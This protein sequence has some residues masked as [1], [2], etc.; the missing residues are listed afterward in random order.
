M[1]NRIVEF[2]NRYKLFKVD[3]T[4]DIYDLL[5]VPGEVTS[6]GTPYAK[7]T[8]LTDQTS[9][10][11][12]LDKTAVPDT[13]FAHIYDRLMW[14]SGDKALITLKVIDQNNKPVTGVLIPVIFDAAG[15]AVKT[16]ADG[17]AKGLIK[18]GSVA[19]SIT[20]YADIEPFN[21][22]KEFVK[23]QVY[24]ETITITRRNYVA[25]TTS[26]YIYFSDDVDTVDAS[27]GGAG[28][29]GGNDT[30]RGVAGDG[31]DYV[32]AGTGSGDGYVTTKE[33]LKPAQGMKYQAIIG[34]G[35]SPDAAGGDTTFM[36][37][38]A[39]GG[40]PKVGGKGG[41]V[42]YSNTYGLGNVEVG[43]KG[44]DGKQS[45]YASFTDTKPYGGKGGGGCAAGTTANGFTP[46]QNSPKPD[47]GKPGIPGGGYGVATG[48]AVDESHNDEVDGKANTGGGGGGAAI[49]YSGSDRQPLTK[50]AG[51]G[52][53][54][55]VTLRIHLK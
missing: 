4:D 51:R 40:I 47:P 18:S 34:A 32:N 30:A 2:P 41:R 31:G 9:K 14:I 22:T 7:E 54:G 28:A 46:G 17:V 44:E 43:E 5:P 3:G 52:G 26:S 49:Y 6:L 15:N 27:V 12:G 53:S 33:G 45:V 25:I 42:H 37:L 29:G 50:T 19:I 38:T 35:G 36:G 16:D 39:N 8:V 1:D 24:T 10:L 13:V 11:Y 20:A 21:L 23:G 55:I 48:F